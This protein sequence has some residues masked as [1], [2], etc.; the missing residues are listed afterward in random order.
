MGI[1]LSELKAGMTCLQYSMPRYDLIPVLVAGT[2]GVG[3][4]ASPLFGAISV[5]LQ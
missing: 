4:G 5:P 2:Y 1:R 3:Q